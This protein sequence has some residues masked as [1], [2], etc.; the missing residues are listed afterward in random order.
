MDKK[1]IIAGGSFAGL[2]VALELC[3]FKNPLTL[4][5]NNPNHTFY[6]D[7]YRM[8]THPINNLK[9]LDDCIK[10]N[11]TMPLDI[12]LE[13]KGVDL[14]ADTIQKID[15]IT[16]ELE[17]EKLG[18]IKFDYLVLALGAKSNYYNIEGA[19]NFST[20]FK[21]I[22]D[23]LKIREDIEK[24]ILKKEQI[25]IVISGGGF[26]GVE[27]AGALAE[28][29]KKLKLRLKKD[30]KVEISILEA[31]ARILLGMPAW[32]N[33]EANKKLRSLNIKL[34]L[35][36]QVFEVL[37]DYVICKDQT[38]V[39]FDYLIWTTGIVGVLEKEN[40]KGI[41]LSK[42]NKIKVKQD[43]S[44]EGYPNI[45]CL[46][47]L[48]EFEDK[49]KNILVPSTAWA[50]IAQGKIVAK[51]ISRRFESKPTLEYN[52]QKPVFVVPIGEYYGLSN[53]FDLK[54]IGISGWIL[55]RVVALKYFL[56]VLPFFKALNFW[57]KEVRI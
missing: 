33:E 55:K 21:S 46:G 41:T 37:K 3:K 18:N 45:F 40:I 51:N 56:S 10:S 30:P 8:A 25:R 32:C 9:S 7:L 57:W 17:L 15:L 11:L 36:H 49:E 39:S 35:N 16:K 28:Y 48:S 5:T 23:A 1:I 27:L 34:L 54:I 6:A 44:I 24:L 42:N 22:L 50:A 4:I 31:S 19:K 52:P 53:A 14:V 43:L 20:P 13:G 12:I 47:D 29:I 38:K 26:T 2:S